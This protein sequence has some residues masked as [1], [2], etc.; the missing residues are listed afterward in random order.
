[1]A[2]VIIDHAGSNVF[3]RK[4][5]ALNKFCYFQKFFITIAQKFECSLKIDA[6]LLLCIP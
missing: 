6:H 3:E 4:L 5:A 2:Y 1:M